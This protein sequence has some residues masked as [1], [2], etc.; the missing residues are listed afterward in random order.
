MI[1]KLEFLILTLMLSWKLDAWYWAYLAMVVCDRCETQAHTFSL[2]PVSQFSSADWW[3][4][5]RT[6]TLW[7]GFA[8][9]N[10]L[11]ENSPKSVSNK[12]ILISFW[13]FQH[14]NISWSLNE[15]NVTEKDSSDL[16]TKPTYQR[17]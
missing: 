15:E 2:C 4:C 5:V 17:A 11:V 7:S 13:Y 3:I 9:T 6:S 14:S 1:I 12:R 8:S 16:A 10:V